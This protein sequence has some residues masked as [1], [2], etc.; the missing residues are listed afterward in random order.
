MA[1]V[2]V[3]SPLPASYLISP[4]RASETSQVDPVARAFRPLSPKHRSEYVRPFLDPHPTRKGSNFLPATSRRL[5][6]LTKP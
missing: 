5:R 3:I 1:K 2:Y 4:V 6:G